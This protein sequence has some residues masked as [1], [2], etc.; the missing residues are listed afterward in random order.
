MDDLFKRFEG[1][2]KQVIE[3]A[4][5]VTKFVVNGLAAEGFSLAKHKCGILGTDRTQFLAAQR[6]LK[7]EGISFPVVRTI[8]DLGLDAGGG[9][10]RSVAVLRKRIGGAK[11]RVGRIRI[12]SRHDRRA[13]KFFAT[14]ARPAAVWGSTAS[15]MSRRMLA[16]MRTMA[17]RATGAVNSAGA[18]VTSTLPSLSA[19]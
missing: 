4:A 14:N 1:T 3:R 2:G 6:H 16:S 10:Q 12:L 13:A 17:A 9:N 7:H 11:G 15:G 8:R 18:C 19:R 5:Q